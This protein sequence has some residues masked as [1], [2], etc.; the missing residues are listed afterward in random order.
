MTDRASPS[1]LD[2]DARHRIFV[3][4]PLAPEIRDAAAQARGAL[5]SY[6]D[7]LR[8]VQPQHLHLTLQFLG[9]ITTSQLEK[10]VDAT[11][12]VAATETAFSITFA[13]LGA[14]PSAAAPRVVWVGVTDGAPRVGALAER[15]GRALRAR[16][17]RLEE[18][19]FAPHLTL[20]RVRG[21]GRPP[22]LRQETEAL[23]R[24]VLGEQRVGEIEVV[25]SV[26]GT[27]APTHTVVATATLGS[28]SN[29]VRG[30]E[31]N[32]EGPGGTG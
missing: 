27:S 11:E 15:L 7:R 29:K 32:Q 2:P 12:E 25:K 18:R 22:D 4:V 19:P 13:G 23:G 24:I 21:T 8:W 6:G 28:S 3:A 20:A 30:L 14:F 17:F 1:H 10:A 26:L 9:D 31:K 5:S 16:H